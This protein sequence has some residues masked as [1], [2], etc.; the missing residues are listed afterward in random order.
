MKGY[1]FCLL[2]DIAQI[3]SQYDWIIYKTGFRKKI[4]THKNIWLDKSRAHW[5]QAMVV[6]N[7]EW[8]LK[9]ILTSYAAWKWNPIT[10]QKQ[11]VIDQDTI[12][13]PASF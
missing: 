13:V 3:I 6:D 2:A 1:I 4:I 10:A 12:L 8:N 5:E 9:G 7:H 11:L